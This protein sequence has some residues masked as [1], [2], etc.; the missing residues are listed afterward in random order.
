MVK[1]KTAK[2]I[3]GAFPDRDKSGFDVCVEVMK[4]EIPKIDLYFVFIWAASKQGDAYW[5]ARTYGSTP[6]DDQTSQDLMDI[7]F[8]KG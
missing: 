8:Q 5:Y 2:Q 1:F 6:W 4:G 7:M 3:I